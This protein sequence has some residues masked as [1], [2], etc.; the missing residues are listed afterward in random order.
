MRRVLVAPNRE[1]TLSER[2]TT[3]DPQT[4]ELEGW[5][6]DAEQIVDGSPEVSGFVLDTSADERVERGVWQHTAGVSSDTESDE[7]FI[8]LSGR[9]TIEVEGGETLEV[10]PGTVGLLHEGD[11]T[12]WRVH[13]TLRKIYQ[14]TKP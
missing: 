13:E 14:V 1:L 2:S 11:R 4:M 9:A 5:P 6:L 3:F 10:E 12:I 8:V 7:F